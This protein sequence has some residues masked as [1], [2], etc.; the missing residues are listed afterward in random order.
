MG[1]HTAE[2]IVRS[3]GGAANIVDLSHCATR[4]RF[5]LRDASG[6][7]QSEVEGVAGVMGAVPQAGDRYQVVIGGAVQSVYNDIKALP[8]M[9][10]GALVSWAAR[11]AVRN[12]SAV[13][14]RISAI[15]SA[16]AGSVWSRPRSPIT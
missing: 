3:V 8:G 12:A 14:R 4:L 15:S 1:S 9:G 16:V 13:S 2:E 11:L 6:V 5:Q 7:K 10:G